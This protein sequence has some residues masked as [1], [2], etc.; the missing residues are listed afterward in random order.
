M[1]S[2]LEFLGDKIKLVGW[3]RYAAGLDTKFNQSG[4]HGIY[5]EWFGREIIFHI[6]PWIYSDFD[7]I[8]E[9]KRHLGND[10][11]IIIY[12]EWNSKLL[13]WSQLLSSRQNH[14]FII[15][16][17]VYE[18]QSFPLKVNIQKRAEVA[19]FEGLEGCLLD[20]NDISLECFND[21]CKS[22]T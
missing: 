20:H 4:E 9:R 21:L 6:S 17:R 12:R 22:Y 19:D 13:N 10:L 14:V 5:R 16:E 1:L 8:L 3:K 7:V 2:F 11:I 18:F 15:V